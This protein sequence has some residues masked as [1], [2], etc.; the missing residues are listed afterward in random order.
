MGWLADYRASAPRDTVDTVDTNSGSPGPPSHCV[1]SVNSVSARQ[2]H[3]RHPEG[4]GDSRADDAAAE[5]EERAAIVAEGEHRDPLTPVPHLLPP[6]WSMVTIEPTAGARCR[7]CGG[8]HWWSEE[9]AP[10]GWRCATCHPA[11]HLAADQ[12]RDVAT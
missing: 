1:N 10:R 7:S 4:C 9:D 6:S 3:N 11:H 2:R 5:A 8:R 12:R